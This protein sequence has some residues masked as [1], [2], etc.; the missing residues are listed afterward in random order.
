MN[1]SAGHDV[2]Q[3][4]PALLSRNLRLRLAA[5]D[6][7]GGGNLLHSLRAISEHPEAPVVLDPDKAGTSLSITHLA[8]RADLLSA[9]YLAREVRPGD[10][11][12]VWIDDDFDY[13]LHAQALGQIGAIGVMMNG[14]L[15]AAPASQLLQRTTPVGI[16]TTESRL[17]R[18]E[19]PAMA[20][21]RWHTPVVELNHGVIGQ[22]DRVRHAPSDPVM[23][24]HSS[25]TTGSP[26]PVVHTHASS[27]A[28]ARSRLRTFDETP[29]DLVLAVQPNSHVG[30][31]M[32]FSYL[33]AAG[34]RFVPHGDVHGSSLPELIHR[35]RPTTVVGFA[36][37]YA[38]LAAERP[39]PGTL[40]PVTAWISMGDSVHDGHVQSVLRGCTAPHAAVYDRFGA[41]EF[42]WGILLQRRGRNATTAPRAVGR[43]DAG[44]GAAVLR[45]DGTHAEVGEVGLFGARGPS[46]TSGYWDDPELTEQCT[47]SEYWLSGDLVRI[48][49]DGVFYHLD[50]AVD[51]GWEQSVPFQ[52]VEY[53][54]LAINALPDQV[55]DITMILSEQEVIAFVVPNNPDVLTRALRLAISELGEAAGQPPVDEVRLVTPDELP[56]GATGKVLKNRLRERLAR[57]AS[58]GGC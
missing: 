54:E 23:I 56:T 3:A 24:V 36:H 26:K 31:L 27:F 33:L 57:L 58:Q 28:G 37:V 6:R 40:D 50:R 8:E 49:D 47:L 43:P 32:Y 41:S 46:L 11:V 55:A 4:A 19:G 38:E 53:E 45:R 25:G 44:V 52:S 48:D 2:T 14:N 34:A 30:A 1:A 29:G 5:D 35:L 42:G 17:T 13:F 18:L 20:S 10:R 16:V 51:S 9:S 12:A 21:A 39:L 7:V 15:A 22:G